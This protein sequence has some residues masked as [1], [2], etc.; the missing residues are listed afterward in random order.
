MPF[1]PTAEAYRKARARG[2]DTAAAAIMVGA[3]AGDYNPALV[4][5]F[6]QISRMT[7]EQLS[8][9]SDDDSGDASGN[10]NVVYVNNY[11]NGYGS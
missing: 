5:Q 4:D 6:H 10:V 11:R 7:R 3:H 8:A 9:P 2:D 1:H